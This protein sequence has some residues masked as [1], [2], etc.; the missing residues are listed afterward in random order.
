MRGS[1]S[2]A[3]GVLIVF[4]GAPSPPASVSAQPFAES[5]EPPLVGR[6]PLPPGLAAPLAEPADPP[7]PVVSLHVRAPAG[8]AAGQEI[9]YRILVENP[10]RAAAHHV[11]VR[12]AVPAA[13]TFVRA[14]PEPTARDPQIVWELDTLPPGTSK[15]ILLTLK[16]TEDGDIDVT[17]RVQ[18]EHGESVRT[19][20]GAGPAAASP[21]PTP[22]PTPTPPAAPPP[23][24]PA[25]APP[26]VAALQVRTAGPTHALVG[27]VVPF[28]LTVINSGKADA[29]NVELDESLPE[30]LE[31]L[32]GNGEWN[33]R[34]T[35]RLENRP[36][37]PRTDGGSGLAGVRAAGRGAGERGAGDGRRRAA[38]DGFVQG[39]G[40]GAEAEREDRR[41]GER[42]PQSAREVSNHGD[43]RRPGAPHQR[44]GAGR[45]TDRS[46]VG[47]A[48]QPRRPA[49]R[50]PDSLAPRRG[51][52]RQ[53]G[54]AH[55]RADGRPRDRGR[56]SRH[57]QGRPRSHGPGGGENTL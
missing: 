36:T 19:H 55:G 33:R 40:A 54:D 44:G 21:P 9:D 29:L 10:S 57:G 50:E 46:A 20:V 41:P 56:P 2:W 25:P 13:A 22:P 38:G 45:N 24:A 31:A 49:E 28:Q 11:R 30:G 43:E 3:L 1:R 53:G 23:V 17:A 34:E 15:E 26:A 18:F 4:A 16:P 39:S 48:A 42:P 14:S 47:R 6:P 51:P 32:G 5:P 7:T 37:G 12:S 35:A 52:S 8:A 27:D